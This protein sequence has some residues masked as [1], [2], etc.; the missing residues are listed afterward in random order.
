[1]LY[2]DN[3]G[4]RPALKFRQIYSVGHQLSDSRKMYSDTFMY[5][6]RVF[7]LLFMHKVDQENFSCSMNFSNIRKLINIMYCVRRWFVS[8]PDVR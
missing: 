8:A 2:K 7:A 4:G 5:F 3:E 6:L 1:M